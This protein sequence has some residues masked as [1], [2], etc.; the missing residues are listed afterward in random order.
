MKKKKRNMRVIV[1]VSVIA[2]LT[3]YLFL[4]G[5]YS[6]FKLYQNKKEYE[7]TQQEIDELRIGIER[8]KEINEKLKNK[9]PLEMEKKA[10]EK[11]MVKDGET[12]YKY[13]IEK[14]N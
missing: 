8:Q 2:F 14:E 1:F 7:K 13:E 4:R 5:D 6:I 3:Y 10:R 12:I 9:D 11:G